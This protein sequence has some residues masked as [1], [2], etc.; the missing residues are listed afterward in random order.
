MR[1]LV[2][3]AAVGT[4]ADAASCTAGSSRLDPMEWA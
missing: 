3:S 4:V 1:E 2:G